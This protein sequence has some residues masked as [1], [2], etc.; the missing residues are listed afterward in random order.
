MF[1]QHNFRAETSV[2]KT[3]EAMEQEGDGPWSLNRSLEAPSRQIMREKP[4]TDDYGK[5][6]TIRFDALEFA[7]HNTVCVYDIKTAN[8]VLSAKRMGHF[9]ELL[10]RYGNKLIVVIQVK[11]SHMY[12]R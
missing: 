1:S 5:F 12:M 10:S 9:A 4:I 6:G 2:V 11:P 3:L 7:N 8:A